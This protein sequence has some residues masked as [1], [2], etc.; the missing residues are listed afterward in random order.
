M[1]CASLLAGF[2]TGAAIVVVILLWLFFKV[3]KRREKA[4]RWRKLIFQSSKDFPGSIMLIVGKI[5]M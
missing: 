3:R 2:L 4:R 5:F 1:K